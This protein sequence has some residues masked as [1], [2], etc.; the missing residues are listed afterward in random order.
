MH[1]AWIFLVFS[2]AGSLAAL[3]FFEIGFKRMEKAVI[4]RDEDIEEEELEREE[5]N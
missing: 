3:L 4:R 5:F 1:Y 2:F